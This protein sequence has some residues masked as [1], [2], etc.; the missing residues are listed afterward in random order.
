VTL[1]LG[2]FSILAF[3]VGL[4]ASVI[5]WVIALLINANSGGLIQTAAVVVG[6][7]VLLI[8]LGFLGEMVPA[9]A[10]DDD[11]VDRFREMAAG[12]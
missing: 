1:R 5:A 6:I 12:G 11:E 3:V 9:A 8:V 2:A 10:D 4:L 7:I